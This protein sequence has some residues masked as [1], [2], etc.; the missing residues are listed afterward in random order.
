[1]RNVTYGCEDHRLKTMKDAAHE[2][3]SLEASGL[4][5]A[6]K[7]MLMN[8]VGEAGKGEYAYDDLVADIRQ[9]FL[10]GEKTA[11]NPESLGIVAR[12]H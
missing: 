3:R 5:D 4:C 10:S 8:S 12:S 11:R 9:C 2:K 6:R 1:M 7:L